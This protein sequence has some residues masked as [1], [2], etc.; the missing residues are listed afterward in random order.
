ML[1]YLLDLQCIDLY[2]KLMNNNIIFNTLPG[3]HN[4]L[5]NS[6]KLCRNLFSGS[7]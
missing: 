3:F 2:N 6:K 1:N 5:S 7:E 4:F